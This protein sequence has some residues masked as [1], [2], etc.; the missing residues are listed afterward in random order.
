[1]QKLYTVSDAKNKM[2]FM[3]EFHKG[4]YK[5]CKR[6]N[7][8]DP[9]KF[10]IN[11]LTR[12]FYATKNISN[13]KCTIDSGYADVYDNYCYELEVL[14]FRR[15]TSFI[16]ALSE[17][18]DIGLY[19][20]G[21]AFD[22]ELP[23]ISISPK[24]FMKK[25]LFDNRDD[26]DIY[27]ED[28]DTDYRMFYILI[29]KNGEKPLY[30]PIKVSEY[31][32][33]MNIKGFSK[34]ISLVSLYTL[35][36]IYIAFEFRQQIDTTDIDKDDFYRILFS[37]NNIVEHDPDLFDGFKNFL[38]SIEIDNILMHYLGRLDMSVLKRCDKQEVEELS[39][40][41]LADDEEKEK[42][43]ERIVKVRK[44]KPNEKGSSTTIAVKLPDSMS[45]SPISDIS[46]LLGSLL[47]LDPD[48]TIEDDD[49]DDEEDNKKYDRPTID[50][51]IDFIDLLDDPMQF[52]DI[53]I[54]DAKNIIIAINKYLSTSRYNRPL[55]TSHSHIQ[56]IYEISDMVICIKAEQSA[57][58][59]VTFVLSK[60]SGE[61][62][63]YKC[64][65]PTSRAQSSKNRYP[66]IALTLNGV[67][68]MIELRKTNMYYAL[69]NIHDI[70]DFHDDCMRI[71]MAWFGRYA[72]QKANMINPYSGADKDN[73]IIIQNAN[74]TSIM[75]AFEKV[76]CFNNEAEI[77]AAIRLIKKETSK[78]EFI[79][80]WMK[81][82]KDVENRP[83]IIDTDGSAYAYENNG[84]EFTKL[85]HKKVAPSSP[86][87]T[88]MS[89]H[90]SKGGKSITA[91]GPYLSTDT[92]KSDI[93]S[94]LNY[95]KQLKKTEE[96]QDDE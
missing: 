24:D 70:D 62:T 90:I 91:K 81:E 50:D 92:F 45:S 53:G 15:N 23:I 2:E 14:D 30:F 36:L 89:F 51:I 17:Y 63:M 58:D 54:V 29:H 5:L 87:Y 83:V 56:K 42:D 37:S 69:K 22:C 40:T 20:H 35:Q 86:F 43:D 33:T 57:M 39:F 28:F 6:V 80:P 10:V 7:P 31:Q 59:I 41:T 46:S 77:D 73:N 93:V 94:I 49:N 34:M 66:S 9:V 12:I 55:I 47:G 16:Y 4:F 95:I 72:V 38:D 78:H 25:E 21:Y 19:R 32:S 3:S 44:N 75:N 26:A 84:N 88:D 96:Q 8:D 82:I 76:D 18:E 64:T 65:V 74:F 68:T 11:Q 79:C 61:Y 71:L 60:V 13:M 52:L 67:G 85:I 27:D 48:D 1:M